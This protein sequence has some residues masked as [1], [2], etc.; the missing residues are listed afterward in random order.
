MPANILLIFDIDGTLTDTV[1]MYHKIFEESLMELGFQNFNSNFNTY[2]HHTDSFVVNEINRNQSDLEQKPNIISKFERLIFEKIKSEKISEIEGAKKQIEKLSKMKGI[3]ICYATGSVYQT[4][5][6]KLEQIGITFSLD[7]LS[8]SNMIEERENILLEAIEIAQK[9]KNISRFDRI[10]SIGDGIWDLKTA[11]NLNLDF[12]G[13]GS[14][15]KNILL[16]N[17]MINWFKNLSTFSI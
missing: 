1:S 5:K 8:C 12:I 9:K 11:Q 13:I 6:Y 16:E 2:K 10:I 4:A 7:Q 3:T 14:K 15:N 17:G